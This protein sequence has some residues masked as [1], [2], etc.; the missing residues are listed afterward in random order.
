M[1]N[2]NKI[3]VARERFMYYVSIYEDGVKKPGLYEMEGKYT[4]NYHVRCQECE[5]FWTKETAP[6]EI[7]ELVG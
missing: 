1:C 5:T 2:H 6:K 3:E 7:K 4:G